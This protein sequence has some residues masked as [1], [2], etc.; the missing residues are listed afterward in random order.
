VNLGRIDRPID[1]AQSDDPQP[2]GEK[3]NVPQDASNDPSHRNHRRR[4]CVL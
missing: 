2:K 3:H 4:V 1:A